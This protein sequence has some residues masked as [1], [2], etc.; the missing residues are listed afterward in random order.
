MREIEKNNN[1]KI[2]KEVFDYIHARAELWEKENE[3]WQELHAEYYFNKPTDIQERC[4][5]IVREALKCVNEAICIIDNNTDY[6]HSKCFQDTITFLSD[7]WVDFAELRKLE[8]MK[9]VEVVEY[10]DNLEGESVP[11]LLKE[12]RVI[13]QA[14]YDIISSETITNLW[15]VYSW[16]LFLYMRALIFTD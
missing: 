1:G 12:I 2:P 11:S 15:E 6:V 14:I 9:V 7:V 3:K 13:I 5:F 8:T 10:I 16:R 4:L